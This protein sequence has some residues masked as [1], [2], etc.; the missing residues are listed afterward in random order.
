[1][2]V[3][4]GFEDVVAARLALRTLPLILDRPV[5]SERLLPI[6]W[7]VLVCLKGTIDANKLVEDLSP[8]PL[9]S[10]AKKAIKA[11]SRAEFDYAKALDGYLGDSETAG[12]LADMGAQYI[13]GYNPGR[14]IDTFFIYSNIV[15]LEGIELEAAAVQIPGMS[16]IELSSLPLWGNGLA[17]LPAGLARKCVSFRNSLE[18]RKEHWEVWTQWYQDRL[19]GKQIDE[20]DRLMRLKVLSRHYDPGKHLDMKAVNL[21][22]KNILIQNM[23]KATPLGET[24]TLNDQGIYEIE[25]LPVKP[26]YE[27]GVD[28]VK[29]ALEKVLKTNGLSQSSFE[30]MLLENVFENHT[31]NPQRIYDDFDQVRQMISDDVEEGIID[32]NKAIKYLLNTLDVATTDLAA[33]E[34]TIQESIAA[35]KLFK[36]PKRDQLPDPAGI[37][38]EELKKALGPVT[39]ERLGGELVQDA[40]T[41][42][43]ALKSKNIKDSVNTGYRLASRVSR[44]IL[45][46]SDRATYV[47]SESA[48]VP[49]TYAMPYLEKLLKLLQGI[50]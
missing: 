7:C 41:F 23:A 47:T 31:D 10:S 32:D 5:R 27:S 28:R 38:I 24:L 34:T 48:Q 25:F 4:D 42:M 39:E 33:N 50:F 35:R 44:M 43:D 13:A 20:A 15:S 45:L 22:I 16:K 18:E 19:E 6:F 1:M 21:E 12:L 2:N 37:D 30:T 9:S 14:L 11:F 49:L 26:L 40:L 46:Y 17:D 3:F 36:A 29:F 8:E